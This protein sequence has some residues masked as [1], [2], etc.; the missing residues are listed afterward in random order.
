MTLSIKYNDGKHLSIDMIRRLDRMSDEDRKQM[1]ESLNM[2]ASGFH[3]RVSLSGGREKKARESLEDF[4]RQVPLVDIGLDRW[5]VAQNI[6]ECV[7][8]TQAQA[9]K[10]AERGSKFKHEFRSA[11]DT[12]AGRVLSTETPDEIM[13]RRAQALRL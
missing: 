9:E 3:T 5:I 7:P 1:G 11:V 12:V 6:V 4:A 2:D 10:A 8:F 13:R